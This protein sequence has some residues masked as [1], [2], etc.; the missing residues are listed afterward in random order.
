MRV[1]VVGAGLAGAHVARRLTDA[2]CAVRVFEKA[3]GA[4]GRMSTRRSDGGA[5]D[6]GAQYFTARDLRFAQQVEAWCESGVAAPFTGRIVRLTAGRPRDE[7]RAVDRF[8]GAP[9]MNAVVKER[10][11]DIPLEAGVRIVDIRREAGRWSLRSEAGARYGDF[12]LVVLAIPPAQAAPLLDGV[13]ALAVR[14]AKARL[15]PCHA[16]MFVFSSPLDV[17][18][19]GAFVDGDVLAWAMRN[20]AKPGREGE[21]CWV[22]HTRAEWSEAN[23]DASSE[24]VGDAATAAFAVA[25]GR[26]LPAIRYR[27]AHRWLFARAAQPLDPTPLFEPDAGMGVCGDWVGGDRVEDAFLSA[28][29]LASA[30]VARGAG[31]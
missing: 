15:A 17:S 18:F 14:A 2:G 5:F 11:A 8:V 13:P 10:L 26:P 6:H 1:A 24:A 31:A 21:G 22:V 19:D 16:V 27:A 12:D 30:I 9:R 29:R 23:V 28:E 4:G 25:L 20:D 7:D 3:R